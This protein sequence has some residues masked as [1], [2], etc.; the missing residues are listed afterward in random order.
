MCTARNS[1]LEWDCQASDSQY[2]EKKKPPQ[3]WRFSASFQYRIKFMVLLFVFN[4]LHGS[5]PQHIIYL[6]LSNKF[7]HIFKQQY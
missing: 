2:E 6:D 7:L 3:S 1:R 4:P 5:A